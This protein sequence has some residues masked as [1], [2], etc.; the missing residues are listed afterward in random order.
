MVARIARFDHSVA[1]SMAARGDSI[2]RMAAVLG[3]DRSTVSRFITQHKDEITRAQMAR[4]DFAP[5]LPDGTVESY[6]AQVLARAASAA[7]GQWKP[8][9]IQYELMCR[10]LGWAG[11]ER[12]G[13]E[14]RRRGEHG[15]GGDAGPSIT[16]NLGEWRPPTALP[17]AEPVE[18]IDAAGATL[19]AATILDDATTD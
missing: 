2:R 5:T 10:F 15:A 4:S 18:V 8:D 13:G 9:Q 3:C 17:A 6:R 7:M 14:A 16:V 1:V 11:P 19:D 12:I